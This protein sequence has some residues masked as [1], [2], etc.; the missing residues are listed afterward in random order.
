MAEIRLMPDDQLACKVSFEGKEPYC[1]HRGFEE[2]ELLFKKWERR[3]SKKTSITLSIAL[4][5]MNIT[6]VL[7]EMAR[8]V[9]T[10]ARRSYKAGF[11]K[12]RAA[13]YE[14]ARREHPLD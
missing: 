5:A 8:E 4:K 3:L 12:G 10:V 6:Y 13:G 7:R 14:A 2:G 9:L 1:T 11:E